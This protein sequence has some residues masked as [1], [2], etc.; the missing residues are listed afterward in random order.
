[1]DI[2]KLFK[3]NIKQGKVLLDEP[4]K[5]HTYFKIGGPVDVMVLPST[6]REIQLALKICRDNNI[7]Y[8]IIGNGT[9]LLVKDKGIRG[10]VIKLG[11]NFN[12][13]EVN[14]TT[15]TSQCGAYLS[16]ISKI[17]LKHSLKGM[18]GIS[19]IPGSLGGAVAMNAG[20]YG[21]EIKDVVSK[22]KCLDEKG[23]LKEYTNKQMNFS[24]RHS[25][26]QDEN[27]LVVEVELKLQR[28]NYEQIKEYMDELTEK[29]T[30]K[31]PLSMA[32]AGSTFKRPEGDYAA[33]LI[34]EAGLKG[35]RYGNAQVSDKHCG[36]V[37]NLGDATSNDV[38]YL[39]KF[40]Q[41]V[42]KD[43]FDID[44]HTEVKIIGEE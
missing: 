12:K 2:Y 28:G 32:S 40:I 10:V 26:V 25:R 13:I 31:Q 37:I 5:K 24:Y 30:S 27:L 6:I 23:N 21:S 17:A 7:K 4:M 22:V 42:V 1:M 41:K 34:D 20:A 16:R 38:L 43:K 15:I 14:G 35:V 3:N 44:L 11:E 29:R 8:H 9:N 36:F 33:R 19:G 18:E 39:I